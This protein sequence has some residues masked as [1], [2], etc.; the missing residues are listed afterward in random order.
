M[1]QTLRFLQTE[2]S[3]LQAEN[4]QLHDELYTL[5]EYISTLAALE[6]AAEELT[7]EQE[8]LPLLDKILYYALTLLDSTDGSVI[9]VDEEADECVFAVVRGAIE[10]SLVNFRMPRDEGLTGWV[11]TEGLPLIVNDVKQDLRFSPQV[12]RLYDFD[13]RTMLCVP[14]K[15][16]KR[17]LGAISVINKHSGEDFTKIDL[18][19]LSILARTAAFALSQYE[20]QLT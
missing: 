17:V 19:L 10:S 6:S 14:M 3:R 13:T 12:D 18:D 15:V 7:S 4:R 2:N 20:Q 5:Q 1:D 8:L 9:L 11:V 16:G